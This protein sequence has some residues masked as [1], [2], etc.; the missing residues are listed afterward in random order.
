MFDIAG[1]GKLTGQG[2]RVRPST[3]RRGIQRDGDEHEAE[4]LENAIAAELA[5]LTPIMRTAGFAS[6]T[7]LSLSGSCKSRSRLARMFPGDELQTC[8]S[9]PG[10]AARLKTVAWPETP[11]CRG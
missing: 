5:P 2:T 4:E 8:R 7:T 9:I 6:A 11:H 1:V 10:H 3:Q